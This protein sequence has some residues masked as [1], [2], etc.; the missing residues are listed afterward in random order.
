MPFMVDDDSDSVPTSSASAAALYVL[1]PCMHEFDIRFLEGYFRHHQRNVVAPI[2]CPRCSS[3]VRHAPHFNA[4]L[5]ERN[6]SVNEAK[7]KQA[8]RHGQFL[9]LVASSQK[10][11]ALLTDTFI[12]YRLSGGSGG[13]GS[14]QLSRGH[15]S[16]LSAELCRGLERI[17]EALK[18]RW[19]QLD[20]LHPRQWKA[21]AAP[22]CAE[23]EQLHRAL[24]EFRLLVQTCVIPLVPASSDPMISTVRRVVEGFASKMFQPPMD[25]PCSAD[26]LHALRCEVQRAVITV[27]GVA[28]EFL[29]ESEVSLVLATLLVGGITVAESQALHSAL[30][31]AREIRGPG[32][33]RRCSCGYLYV[34][35]NCAEGNEL[36]PC[37]QCN[38]PIGGE[39]HE[40]AQ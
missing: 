4:V 8:A 32:A 35:G 27:H 15:L 40:D 19:H 6:N 10:T 29:S 5:S 24:T 18:K 7:T 22:P 17:F 13:G 34:I 12:D 11:L 36:A 2:V 16:N 26:Q 25:D 30:V 31:Q 28:T 33:W 9:A 14:G 1:H 20:N 3:V 23:H 37:P 38:L 21:A 39:Y